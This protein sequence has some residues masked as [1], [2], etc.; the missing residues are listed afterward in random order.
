MGGLAAGAVAASLGLPPRA[1]RSAESGPD[2][3]K[4]K[5]E[6]RV[7]LY[8]S[9]DT[10]ILD[11]IIAAF[12]KKYGIDV[13]Y[14][15]G[16]SADV[17]SKVLAEADA[18][19]LQADM[20]DASDVGAFLVMNSRGLLE[21]YQSPETKTVPAELRDADFAWVA[22]R[23]T[24]AV[25]QYNTEEFGAEP[26]AHWADL[27]DPRFKGRLAFFSSSNGDGAPRLYTLAK[28]VGWDLLKEYAAG[29]P[30]RVQTPQL[31]NQVIESGERGAGFCQNDNIAWRSKQQGK[32]TDQVYP[33][34]GV[35][36]ELGGVGLVAKSERP[37]AAKLFYDWWM[38]KEGQALLVKGGK[39]SSRTDMDP[40]TGSPPL[41]KIKLL[42]LDYEEYQKNRTDILEKMTDIFGGE[43][44]V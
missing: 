8:T 26:P 18:G 17:T 33:D 42:T 24:Q 12:K 15:R 43:W 2:I 44:G 9:L 39:Y 34:E 22:D 32:P 16:G 21:P 7:V 38:G 25:I 1:A 35:P 3:E 20:V 6:G 23:L 28:H 11:S 37:N 4:A 19:R 40:P 31:I 10:K 41:A 30:L 27:A 29:D 14:Y 36:T 13:S 5:A